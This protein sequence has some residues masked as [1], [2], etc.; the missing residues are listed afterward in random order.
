MVRHESKEGSITDIH[1]FSISKSRLELIGWR[2]L[3]C[4]PEEMELVLMEGAQ[5]LEVLALD[6]SPN[7]A[8][9]CIVLFESFI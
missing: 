3:L 2:A 4:K 9:Y 1:H 7:P 8:T 5:G 6:S